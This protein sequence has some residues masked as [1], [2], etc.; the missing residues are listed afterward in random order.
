MLFSPRKYILHL[1][2]CVI[3]EK[4]KHIV[5][6]HSVKN[7][8]LINTYEKTFEEKE[9]LMSYVKSLV[10]DFQLY[11][12]ALFF[13][14]QIQGIVP[15]SSLKDMNN[16]GINSKNIR[17]IVL[18]NA[19]L[20]SS[21]SAINE[22]KDYFEDYGGV[23]FLYSPLALLSYCISKDI[24]KDST[25]LSLCIYRHSYCVAV[26]ICKGREIYF[27]SFFDLSPKDPDLDKKTQQ[28]SEN[29]EEIQSDDVNIENYDLDGLDN[30][31]DDKLD[32]IKYKSSIKNDLSD[33]GDDMQMCSYI[34]MSL[35]EFY[36]NP[37]YKGNFIDEIVIFDNEN[38]SSAV[39]SYIEN[40][41]FLE[42]RLVQ[43]DTLELMNELM[44]K[45]LNI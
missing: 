28:E 34:F 19:R 12:V 36:D 20:Y 37:L 13:D 8:K 26:I 29:A 45:E 24:S 40:E 16:F 23:D 27:G 21:I 4:D 1:F 15:S 11:Y 35:K 14:K 3:F 17:S 42:P 32:D 41:I 39:L 31:L 44:R 10:S 38:I 33:F 25:K 22:C 7:S 6:A 2:V 18:E 5:R 43:I 30:L 9:K